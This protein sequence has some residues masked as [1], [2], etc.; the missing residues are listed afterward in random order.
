[1]TTAPTQTSIRYE[2]LV[3]GRLFTLVRTAEDVDEGWPS[4]LYDGLFLKVNRNQ[5]LHLPQMRLTGIWPGTLVERAGLASPD[6]A[7]MA[8]P[9]REERQEKVLLSVLARRCG[10]WHTPM[11]GTE[12]SRQALSRLSCLWRE[13]VYHATHER[14]LAAGLIRPASAWVSSGRGGYSARGYQLTGDGVL[15]AI[16]HGLI[17]L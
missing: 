2:S 8:A 17:T 10:A 14:L 15:R 4:D 13:R 16:A 9:T 6:P 1:M 3:A 12:F 11:E 5:I 7:L